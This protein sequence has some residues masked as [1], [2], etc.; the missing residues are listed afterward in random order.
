M[1]GKRKGIMSCTVTTSGMGFDMGTLMCGEWN[2]STGRPRSSRCQKVSSASEKG[3]AG[4]GRMAAPGAIACSAFTSWGA[5]QATTATS[6]LSRG[7][8][9]RM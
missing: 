8:R 2:T 6:R 1:P 3:L 5:A 9:L 7:S 4:P